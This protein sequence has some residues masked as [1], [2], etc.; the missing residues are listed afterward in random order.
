[1]LIQRLCASHATL[2]VG[3]LVSVMGRRLLNLGATDGGLAKLEHLVAVLHDTV[4]DPLHICH[5][6]RLCVIIC[7]V[8]LLTRVAAHMALHHRCG[9]DVIQGG[10]TEIVV[11]NLR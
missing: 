1:M 4:L 8:Y 10:A 9:A 5:L 6:R 3:A 7:H 2:V 11:G